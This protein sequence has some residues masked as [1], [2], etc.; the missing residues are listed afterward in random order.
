MLSRKQGARGD[1]N[2]SLI[3]GI[4]IPLPSIEIQKE[5]VSKINSFNK[6]LNDLSSGIPAE[7]EARKQQ[8]EYYRD[9]L[10]AFKEIC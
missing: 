7:I 3:L 4:T 6:L 5:I 10:L 2:S 8:Y 9:K 1:L